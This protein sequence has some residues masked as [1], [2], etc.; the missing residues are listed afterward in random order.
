MMIPR[1]RC[2]L[3]ALAALLIASPLAAQKKQDG[4]WTNPRAEN[5]PAVFAY[6]GEYVGEV[7]G[8]GKVAA[9]V[10]AL[11]EAGAVQVVVFPGGLPGD[12][13]NGEV[14]ILL[15]GTLTAE[16]IK[17]VPAEG[18]RKYMNGKPT[19]FS[20]TQEFPPPGQ[21]PWS[22]TIH[23]G[24]LTGRTHED[25]L[26]SMERIER[27]S[28]TLGKKA[29]R[30]AVI[31]FDGTSLEHF[32]AGRLEQDTGVLHTDA[33]NVRTNDRFTAYTA[34]L[35]F[36]LPF[37]PK[38]RGQ[39]RGNSG[40]YQA[41]GQE[42]Q[43]LDSFGLEGLKNECGALYGRAAP[44]VNMCLPPLTWQTF[45]VQLLPDPEKPDQGTLT[46]R[47]NG[48]LIHDAVPTRIKPGKLTLQGHGN[49]LQY[50]NIWLVEHKLQETEESDV[51]IKPA[52]K[53]EPAGGSEKS[54]GAE[55][56]SEEKPS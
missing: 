55:S 21:Q 8:G 33:E 31:L 26:F 13:L 9:Q 14:R 1:S 25:K 32:D 4:V 19:G 30:E 5:L 51:D 17:L 43:V 35:E 50:R 48:V 47:H 16:E 41:N 12:G 27:A 44:E 40:F 11:D 20:A 28:P 2:P 23:D 52:D 37:R 6:Q 22:G 49:L 10:I 34:H 42:I 54:D 45:D 46:V 38:A 7:K 3:L 24:K 36:M 39:G 18:D 29:P 15:D 53:Q 56:S